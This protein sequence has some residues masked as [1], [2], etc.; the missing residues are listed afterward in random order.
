L[1]VMKA[2]E[3]DSMLVIGENKPI[4]IVRRS[5]ILNHGVHI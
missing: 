3:I 4:G 5:D 1:R 2:G